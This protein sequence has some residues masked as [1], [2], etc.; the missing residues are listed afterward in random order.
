MNPLD[1]KPVTREQMQKACEDARASIAKGVAV[2]AATRF[3]R[4]AEQTQ[5]TN[6]GA[7]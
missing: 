2:E 1:P 3:L 6:G 4:D 5:N 7:Q